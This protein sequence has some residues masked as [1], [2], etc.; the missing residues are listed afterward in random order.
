MSNRNN[1]VDQADQDLHNFEI[2]DELLE[3]SAGTS[4]GVFALMT[5]NELSSDQV[6]CCNPK[7]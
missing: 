3:A 5:T 7:D 4:G 6:H 2:S 1:I